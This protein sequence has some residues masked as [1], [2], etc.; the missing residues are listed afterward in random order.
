MPKSP[1]TLTEAMSGNGGTVKY[2][3]GGNAYRRA[4]NKLPV[5]TEITDRCTCLQIL[6]W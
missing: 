2:F 6:D 4:E 1:K 5:E 3:P